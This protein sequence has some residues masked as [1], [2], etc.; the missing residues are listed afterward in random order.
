MKVGEPFNPN[1]VFNHTNSVFIPDEILKSKELDAN[2]K[3]V[4][5][6]LTKFDDYKTLSYDKISESCGLSIVQTKRSIQKLQ[7]LK[8]I[9]S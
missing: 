1:K 5:G 2:D 6:A 7:E 9:G 8:I 4:Y 3:L